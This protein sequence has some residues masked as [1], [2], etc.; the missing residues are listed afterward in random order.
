VPTP[1]IHVAVV[2][3]AGEVGAGMAA[4]RGRDL[5]L[6]AGAERRRGGGIR[7]WYAIADLAAF[8]PPGSCEP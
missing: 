1:P 7:V 3:P 4:V 6:A 8:V 2:A 5:D